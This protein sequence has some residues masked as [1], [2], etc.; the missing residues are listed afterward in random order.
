MA[1]SETGLLR[2]R[3][4]A[5]RRLE[6]STSVWSLVVGGRG[7]NSDAGVGGDRGASVAVGV[8]AGVAVGSNGFAGGTGVGG[9]GVAVG[10]G[11]GVGTAV[12]AALGVRVGV[13]RGV[14]VSS[15]SVGATVTTVSVGR[16][17]IGVGTIVGAL[18]A[19]PSAVG[20][21]RGIG[22]SP[23]SHPKAT[24][25]RIAVATTEAAIVLPQRSRLIMLVKRSALGNDT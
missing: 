8:G 9:N 7:G 23:D 22:G 19:V 14:P 20:T 11:V 25:I 17:K 24:V 15:D 3:R 12:G 1:R 5:D 10:C 18:V 6:K 2:R 4:L 16:G 21:A 13:G